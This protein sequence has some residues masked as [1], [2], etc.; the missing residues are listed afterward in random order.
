MISAVGIVVLVRLFPIYVSLLMS[1]YVGQMGFII[2]ALL[3]FYVLGLLLVIGAQ[4]NAYFFD[5]IQP[6]SSSVGN[7]L[8][9]YSDRENARL[10]D[11]DA[12]MV[13]GGLA[14]LD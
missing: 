1:D 14:Q 9:E 12:N 2:I 3:L 6:L 7:V 11:N 10:L 8:Y 13:L 5:E 4:I